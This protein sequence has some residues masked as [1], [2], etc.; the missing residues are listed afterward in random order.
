MAGGGD[1]D[2]DSDSDAEGSGAS[3]G[4]EGSRSPLLDEVDDEDGL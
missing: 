3:D 2:A 4:E 1:S